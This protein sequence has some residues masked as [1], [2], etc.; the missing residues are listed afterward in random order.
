MSVRITCILYF[1][2]VLF[3]AINSVQFS[4][5]P[6][7]CRRLTS[8]RPTQRNSTVVLSGRVGRCELGVTRAVRLATAG[9]RRVSTELIDQSD[10]LI[11]AGRAA[12]T[13][14]V[15]PAFASPL[16]TADVVVRL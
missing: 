16:R 6:A 4:S 13:A 11:D 9:R 5:I 15:W 10:C 7:Y 12:M 2:I 1:V 3:V 14:S 8:Q